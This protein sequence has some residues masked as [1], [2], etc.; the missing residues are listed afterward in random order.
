MRG[1]PETRSL[2]FALALEHDDRRASGLVLLSADF[3]KH[4]P[5]VPEGRPRQSGDLSA[6]EDRHLLRMMTPSSAPGFLPRLKFA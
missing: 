5:Q 6:A 3:I 4:R 2:S 1:K